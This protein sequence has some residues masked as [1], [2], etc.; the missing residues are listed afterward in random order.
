MSEKGYH[1]GQEKVRN[2][3]RAIANEYG[4]S[5]TVPVNES[6]FWFLLGGFLTGIA[7]IF[8]YIIFGMVKLICLGVIWLWNSIK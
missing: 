4:G 8:F 6:I 7:T 2:Y 5:G 3:R 1:I